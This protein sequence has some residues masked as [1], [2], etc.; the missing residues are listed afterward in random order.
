MSITFDFSGR[1]ALVTGAAQGIGHAIATMFHDA[2]AQ[3]AVVD[4]DPVALRAAWDGKERV[5]AHAVDV[6]DS[7]AVSAAVDAVVAETGS[8]DIVVNNAGITRDTVVWKMSDDQWQAVIDVHLKGTF[9]MTRAVVP[10]MRAAGFGRIVNVTSYT[11]LHGTIGQSNY[12]AAKGGIIAFTKTVAKET[13]RF[14]ITVNAISPNAATPMVLAVGQERL[15]EM[16]ATV[17]VGRFADPS[18]MA[19]AVGYLAADE[20]AYV[21]GVVLPVDGGLAM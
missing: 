2:G 9:A 3:V 8:L 12:A 16:T 4:R 11:G 5:F 18:E 20:S 15:A 7:S 19:T 14:G 17:P 10:H 13:A 1:T 21:T 6:T